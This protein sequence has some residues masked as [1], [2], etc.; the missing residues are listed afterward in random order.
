MKQAE[1]PAGYAD[2]G[3]QTFVVKTLYRQMNAFR[4]PGSL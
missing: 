1:I 3:G 4:A 2:D